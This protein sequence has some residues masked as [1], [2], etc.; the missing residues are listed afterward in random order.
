MNPVEPRLREH[1]E[2]RFAAPEHVFDLNE[3]AARLRSEA[4]VGQRGYRQTALYRE[5]PLTM[6][7]FAFEAGG[8]MPE[9]ATPGVVT[10]QV[11]EG[12][13]TVQTPEHTHELTAGA[14][15]VLAPNERHG[16]RAGQA[17]LMLL[18][19]HLE[20]EAPK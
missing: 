14:V 15:L 20:K 17:S 6:V 19:I 16:V 12:A 18:T 4:P 11:I 5:A 13:L 2:A 10:I 9:H 7:L 1:P 8:A 3:A